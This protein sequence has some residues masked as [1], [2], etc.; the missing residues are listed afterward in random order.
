MNS[1]ESLPSWG[2]QPGVGGRRETRKGQ[3]SEMG[4]RQIKSQTVETQKRP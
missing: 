4:L 1:T 3:Y 2:S